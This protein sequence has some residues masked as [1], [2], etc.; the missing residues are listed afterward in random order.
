MPKLKSPRFS[1]IPEFENIRYIR[2]G[3][4]GLVIKKLQ[5]ALVDLGFPLP[6]FGVDGIFGDETESAVKNYQRARGLSQDG[7]VG[8]I[9]IA[10]IDSDFIE[11]VADRQ[12]LDAINLAIK[13]KGAKWIAG[14][15]LTTQL[16]LRDLKSLLGDH[17]KK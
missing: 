8:P 2:K 10:A 12:K 6:K 9:T 15:T 13:R 17:T 5:Q 7:I 4:K 16:N 1:E 14:E 3:D 11:N